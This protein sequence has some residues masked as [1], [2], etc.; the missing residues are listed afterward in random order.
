MISAEAASTC[1]PY[2]LVVGRDFSFL[3]C[4]SSNKPQCPCQGTQQGGR[5]LSQ[6]CLNPD[7]C[8][9]AGSPVG[10]EFENIENTDETKPTTTFEKEGLA[11]LAMPSP[12]VAQLYPC[13]EPALKRAS[14]VTRSSS[15]GAKQVGAMLPPPAFLTLLLNQPEQLISQFLP[16]S[17]PPRLL[18]R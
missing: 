9:P 8:V 18:S 5:G 11:A 3:H 2:L 15:P 12:P 4:F 10:C 17:H 13:S 1:H 16:C 7:E 14:L 6:W